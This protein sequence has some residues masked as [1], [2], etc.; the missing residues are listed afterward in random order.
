M[1]LRGEPDGN[2]ISLR[3]GWHIRSSTQ[4]EE[5]GAVLSS[6]AFVPH[7]WHPATVPT[8]VLN[9]LVK[10]GVYPDPRIG[11]NNF[12]IPD[13]SDEFNVQHDLARYSHLPGGANPW[14]AAYWYRT[15]FSLP[16]DRGPGARHRAP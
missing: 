7:D 1:A 11:L 10:D 14:H 3:A 15:E 12:C 6:G 16:A 2:R 13:A 9:A 8:T 5:D 4:V